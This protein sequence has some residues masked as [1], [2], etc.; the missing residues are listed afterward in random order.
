MRLWCL[1]VDHCSFTA[2]QPRADV[3]A[4]AVDGSPAES[5]ESSDNAAS[6]EGAIDEGVVAFVGVSE[7]DAAAVGRGETTASGLARAAG[8]EIEDTLSS[9]GES[10]VAVLPA[11]ALA[12]TPAA[13]DL[14]AGVCRHLDCELQNSDETRECVR[15]PVGWHLAVDL[16]ARG[17]PVASR[18]RDPTGTSSGAA[19][20]WQVIDADGSLIDADEAAL[21]TPVE[22]YLDRRRS[23]DLGDELDRGPARDAGLLAGETEPALTPAGT[24]VR[25]L[26]GDHLDARLRAAGARPVG[27]VPPATA[28]PFAAGG[29]GA[30]DLPASLYAMDGGGP[31]VWT[32]VGSRE[33]ALD[34]VETQVALLRRWLADAALDVVPVLTVPEGPEI[35]RERLRALAGPFESPVLLERAAET[36]AFGVELVVTNGTGQPLATGRVRLLDA[37]GGG[38]AVSHVVHATLDDMERFTVALC[39]PTETDRL[40]PVWLAPSQV[41]L[42]PLEPSTHRGRCQ[43]L[44]AKLADLGVRVDID[45]RPLAV[46]ERFERAAAAGTPYVAVVGDRELSGETISVTDRGARTERTWTVPELAATVDGTTDGYPRAALRGSRLCSERLFS[47][48]DSDEE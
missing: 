38:A 48:V 29:P 28:G 43:D 17:H 41:R 16:S 23:G 4:G 35:P 11:P 7:D 2:T 44:A 37:D 40:L 34:A 6:S 10:A 20:T 5:P 30:D 25:E 8:E 24:L 14:S 32:A 15:A 42:L 46:G 19:S 18:V 1:H 27:R 33:G 9:L 47:T 26:L 39:H 13:G 21:S 45:D 3:D 22:R 12:P 36:T 31:A